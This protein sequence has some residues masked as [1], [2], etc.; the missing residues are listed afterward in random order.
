MEQIIIPEQ[1][2]YL[3]SEKYRHKIYFN[4][5]DYS[6]IPLKHDITGISL[7]FP[8]ILKQV[9]V[10]IGNNCIAIFDRDM[11]DD[12]AKFPIYLTLATYMYTDIEL[13]YDKKWLEQNEG[14]A[15]EDEYIEAIEYGDDIEIY[16]GY[17]YQFGKKVIRK[18]V[19][20]G[21]QTRTITKSVE[22]RAPQ[23][24]VGI[25]YNESREKKLVSVKQ[26]IDLST[27]D[28]AYMHRLISNHNMRIINDHY[29][30]VNNVIYYTGEIA[31]LKYS[32]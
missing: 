9:R 32:F 28:G 26:K 19:P 24:T 4:R 13:V 5:Y 18:K 27:V 17:D 6:I 22:L 20:S 15:Y 25:A 16:D 29:G 23:I 10:Y 11:K 1:T 31:G 30:Y 21:K 12:L 3:T 2:I 14:Y 7:E 8:D